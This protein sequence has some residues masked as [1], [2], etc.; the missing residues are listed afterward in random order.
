MRWMICAW[1]V[2][3]C[4]WG[5]PSYASGL[6]PWAF[7][8]LGTLNASDA[9]SI[10]ADTLQLTGGASYTGVLDPISG[11]GIFAFDD[12]SG[13]NLSIFGSRT[14]GLLSKSNIA[15][16]GAIDLLGSGGLDMVASG[17]MTLANVNAVGGG[18]T[19]FLT[20][21]QINLGGIVD[22]GNRPLGI[23]AV[24][25]INLTREIGSS[26]EIGGGILSLSGRSGLVVTTGTGIASRTVSLGSGAIML[27]G[28]TISGNTLSG[29]FA[30]S[31]V[32][33]IVGSPGVTFV[34][35]VPLPAA[36]PLFGAGLGLITLM[37]RRRRSAGKK[38][39]D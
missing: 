25:P 10:D 34:A 29:Q 17:S 22:S 36:L 38:N 19:L 8:S 28:G 12:I 32:G 9:I 26:G 15:F 27:T 7:T 20:A 31:S 6:D 3:L 18:Q 13:T 23:R 21:N 14:L 39:G 11:A 30:V 4:L 33:E 1:A 37:L 16:T 24:E 35:P 2:V 5:L